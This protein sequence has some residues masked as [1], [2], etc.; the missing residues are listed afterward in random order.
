MELYVV[1]DCC[2]K[3]YM[4]TLRLAKP[5]QQTNERRLPDLLQTWISKALF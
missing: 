2:I 4:E 3:M 1:H 5:Q